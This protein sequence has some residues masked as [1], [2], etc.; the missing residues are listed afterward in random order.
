MTIKHFKEDQSGIALII[1]M[2]ALVLL[3]ALGTE[4]IYSMRT[5]VNAT[6]NYKEDIES[7]YLARAGINLA[8]A[9]IIKQT[10]FHSLDENKG[11]IFG[12]SIPSSEKVDDEGSLSSRAQRTNIPLG[13]GSL[14]YMIT[15]E[16]GKISINGNDRNLLIKASEAS[17]EKDPATRDIIAD[18]ILDWVDPDD[19][20]RLNGAE[21]E[22]Y[23]GQA[24]QYK[25]R[26]GPIEHLDELLNI[27][28]ITRENLYGTSDIEN[29]SSG[30]GYI[31][32][33]KFLTAQKIHIFNPN[34]ASPRVLSAV[35][36]E[37]RVEEILEAKKEKGFYSSSVSSHFNVVSTGKINN[38]QTQHTII[39]IIEKQGIDHKASLLIR[40]WKD[41]AFEL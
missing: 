2:W 17:G 1:V 13:V 9:E 36:P 33:D 32:L 22:Y 5:E 40:Y 37:I 14:S 29:E 31:G 16:N 4:F 6:R 12:Y 8:M 41:N 26:N 24:V 18:S 27:R 30:T 21:S 19:T 11:F 39:A 25:P 35:Y 28:G 38:S 34:T 23:Q 15:D 3:I 10:A 7:Y 20:H